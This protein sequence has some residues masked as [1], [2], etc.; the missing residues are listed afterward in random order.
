MRAFDRGMCLNLV[1]ALSLCVLAGHALAKEA[2]ITTYEGRTLTGELVAQDE[3]SVTL[4]ISGIKTPIPKRTIQNLEIKDEPAEQ[5]RKMRAELQ[6]DDLD[7]RYRLAYTM[8]EKKWFDLAMVEL[9]SL[10]QSFPDSDKVRALQAVVKSRL[11]RQQETATPAARPVTP[12][13]NSAAVTEVTETPGP[14]TRLTEADI[15]VI[16]VYEADLDA[17]PNVTLPSDTIDKL[18]KDYASDDR[19]AKDQRAFRKLQGYEQLEVLFTLQARELYSRCHHPPG[20]AG[21]ER[22]PLAG[23]PALRPELL[24]HDRLPR[25]QLARWP[26]PVPYPAQQRRHRLHQLLHPQQDE[27]CRRLDD[28]P[29]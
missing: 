26:V 5:Y 13:N 4:L 11:D 27:G 14:D 12:A 17:Q 25:G 19:L 23:P 29:R 15:N 9:K 7:G 18:F 22:F 20:L 3:V 16:R 24:R 8:Y 2:V 6:D 28:R 10:E 21:D 1:C